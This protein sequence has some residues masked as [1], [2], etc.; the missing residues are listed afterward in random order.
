MQIR[1]AKK[2]DCSRILE[3]VQELANYERAPHEVSVTLTEF[4]D[5][6]FGEKPVWKAF[7][8]ETEGKIEGFALYYVRFSTWKGRRLYLED[9]YVT[10]H[11]RGKG[12]G[13]ALFETIIREAKE[14]GFNGMNWQVLDWN[15]PAL[16][17]Y[18]K[19]KAGIE[20]EWL[21]GSFSREQLEN[22]PV[23]TTAAQ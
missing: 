8:A 2:G 6:G 14:Q 12:I 7:V 22:L 21:N 18:S 16:N 15:E 13:K 17:F 19:Y 5:A 10:E 11:T 20:S 4:E 3:L 23:E 1:E 9:F